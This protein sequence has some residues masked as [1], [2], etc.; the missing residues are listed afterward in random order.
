[1]ACSPSRGG[2]S[3]GTPVP[4]EDVKSRELYLAIPYDTGAAQMEQI[5]RAYDYA[6][7]K[8]INLTVWKLK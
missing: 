4:L 7:Q 6:A 8:G 5:K 1:M 2:T 3:K